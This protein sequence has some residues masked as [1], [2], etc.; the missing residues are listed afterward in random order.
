MIVE[1]R[2]G[3]PAQ[4]IYTNRRKTRNAKCKMNNQRKYFSNKAK[5]TTEPEVYN[6]YP[7]LIKLKKIVP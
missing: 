1:G 2:G 3:I 6:I 5:K 7:I 4:G